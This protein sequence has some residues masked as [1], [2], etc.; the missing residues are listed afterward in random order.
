MTGVI[1]TF[2]HEGRESLGM[3]VNSIRTNKL[4]SILT[5]LGIAVGVFS[6]ISVMTAMGVLVNSIQSGMTFLGAS[7]FQVQRT[8][9]MMTGDPK[10]M[11]KMMNRKKINYEQALRVKESATLAT[12]VGIFCYLNTSKVVVAEDGEKTNPNVSI[13]GRDVESFLANNWIIENGR[14][15]SQGEINSGSYV[16]ILGSDVVKK[17]YPKN[18]PIGQTIRVDGRKYQ[19]I[20]TVQPKGSVLGGDNQSFVLIPL[21]T[22]FNVYGKDQE[23]SFKVQAEPI[24]LEDCMEQVTGIMRAVRHV[25]PG[26]EDD[27]SIISNDSL[28][29]QFNDFTKYLRLGIIIISCIALLAAGVGIMNIMLVSVTERTR[30][31]GIRKAIGARKTNIMTQFIL[32]AVLLSEFGGVIGIGLGI[33]GGNLIAIVVEANPI[34]PYDWVA[35]GFISCS[36]IGIIFG[37]YPAWKAANLDPIESLRYE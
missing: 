24:D 29:N 18:D 36:I 1:E 21:N 31:I 13:T 19:V 23:F 11:I 34:V 3:A 2:L 37:V 8:P 32:E 4:R 30:E 10:E 14:L 27:F 16:A 9:A 22:F 6:I 28:I 35:I 15:F 25:P 20:G 12:A 26:A 33:L 5:L 17:L 7:T